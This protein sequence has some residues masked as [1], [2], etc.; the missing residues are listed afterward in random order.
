MEKEIKQIPNLDGYYC[1]RNGNIY[2]KKYKETKML[3]QTIRCDGYLQVVLRNSENYKSYFVHRLI[4]ETFIGNTYGRL[5][6]HINRRKDDNRVCNL[7]FFNRTLNAHNRGLPQNNKSGCKGVH[8]SSR[9]KLWI[10]KIRYNGKDKYL[11][12]FK[13]KQEAINIRLNAEKELLGNII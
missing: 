13:D 11:G 3:N 2:S 5:I 12:C 8:F 9:D 7:R 6:D 1:D 4:A 10:A